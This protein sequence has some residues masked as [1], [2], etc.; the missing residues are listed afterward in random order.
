MPPRLLIYTGSIVMSEKFK[1]IKDLLGHNNLKT[2][3]RYTHVSKQDM[4]K[5][6]SP[7][8]KLKLTK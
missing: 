5:I 2:T 6:K 8:D 7:M 1:Y 3:E 4:S